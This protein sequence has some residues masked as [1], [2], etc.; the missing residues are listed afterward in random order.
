M[1]DNLTS[2]PD[3]VPKLDN[4]VF[5][6]YFTINGYPIKNISKKSCKEICEKNSV[7]EYG[8]WLKNKN[9]ETMCFPLFP[10]NS[11]FNP[12][13]NLESISKYKDEYKESEF[14]YNEKLFPLWSD[15]NKIFYNDVFIIKTKNGYL[16]SEGSFSKDKNK[17]VKVRILKFS[18]RINTKSS[19]PV[20]NND[21]IIL[22][23]LDNFRILSIS[24]S[25]IDHKFKFIDKVNS[26]NDETN[27]FNIKKLDSQDIDL[28]YSD[29]FLLFNNFNQVIISKNL[30]INQN[31]FNKIYD[32][33]FSFI[34]TEVNVYDSK[35]NRFSLSDCKTHNN[36]TYINNKL[37]TRNPNYYGIKEENF[38]ENT[39]DKNKNQIK[40][41]NNILI[42]V[43][44]SILL[45]TIITILL[46]CIL[47]SRK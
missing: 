7:C 33:Y 20:K 8:Y 3:I 42:I 15:T 13:I 39:I 27:T 17:A 37:V 40:P 12:T 1:S 41:N 44:G 2:I 43:I 28:K 34:P 36:K 22:M 38:F 4:S 23:E 26:I 24:S 6:D 10:I 18:I 47:K 32:D 46:I 9:D 35:K 16:T 11:N 19:Y 5:T 29:N 21:K 31:N 25:D 14:F 30:K 45:I